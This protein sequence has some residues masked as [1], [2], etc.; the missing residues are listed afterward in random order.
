LHDGGG[1]G[2]DE[3]ESG[4]DTVG[5]HCARCSEGG[6]SHG[7]VLRQELEGDRVAILNFNVVRHESQGVVGT[8]L[9]DMVD[10]LSKSG[11][12]GENNSE[13]GRETHCGLI[14]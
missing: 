12:N 8:D 3:L 2:W 9:N 14:V 5:H 11:G 6:L 4:I 1:V 7:V 13:D 10:T